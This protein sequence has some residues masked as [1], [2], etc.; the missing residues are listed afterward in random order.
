MLDG[1][2]NGSE[3]AL[4][5][6]VGSVEDCDGAYVVLAMGIINENGAYIL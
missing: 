5:G 1:R 2:L 4:V 3:S 6:H